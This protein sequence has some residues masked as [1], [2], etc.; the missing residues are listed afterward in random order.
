[1]KEKLRQAYNLIL[2]H[3]CTTTHELIDCN[4]FYKHR[5][6]KKNPKNIYSFNDKE[7]ILSKKSTESSKIKNYYH[8]FILYTVSSPYYSLFEVEKTWIVKI[9]IKILS[10]L[11]IK[12]IYFQHLGIS[13][14]TLW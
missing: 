3:S 9:K 8:F 6:R 7:S 2:N 4:F 5:K 10:L 11:R 13:L 1:M 14:K 12:R